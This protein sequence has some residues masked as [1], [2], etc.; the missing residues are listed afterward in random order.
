M[1]CK[2]CKEKCVKDG[3]QSN[4]SQRYECKSCKKKQKKDINIMLMIHK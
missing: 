4:G 1:K 3:S 2:Y